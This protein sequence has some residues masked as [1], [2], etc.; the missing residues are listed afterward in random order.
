MIEL[1][2]DALGQKAEK[3]LLPMQ[4]GDVQSTHADVDAIRAAVG[5]APSTPFEEGVK[6]FADWYRSYTRGE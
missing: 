4:P 2:E 6:H 1:L 3:E 5:Y